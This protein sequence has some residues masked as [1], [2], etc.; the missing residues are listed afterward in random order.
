MQPDIERRFRRSHISA[1]D[2]DRAIDFIKEARKHHPKSLIYDALLT[3]A[4]IYYARPFSPN[5]H[6]KN[7]DP[8]SESTIDKT[9]RGFEDPKEQKFHDE[10]IELRNKVVA[11]AEYGH[12]KYTV[13]QVSVE[14]T[15]QTSI[16]SSVWR[17]SHEWFDLF[18]FERI[19]TEMRARCHI[20][21]SEDLLMSYP[22]A[23]K[24]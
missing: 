16:L 12:G 8:L 3:S 18:K 22:V 20:A 24:E 14:P 10:I 5:E 21:V 13:N 15:G 19:A 9:L 7:P 23:A 1:Y 4:I 2:F 17:P 6:W 11:H